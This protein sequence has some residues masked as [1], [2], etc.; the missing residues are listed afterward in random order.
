MSSYFVGNKFIYYV[1][2]YNRIN[3]TD[4]NF[5][6]KFENLNSEQF[7]R[8]VVLSASIPKSF[9][10]IQSGSNTFVLKENATQ[11]TI[12]VPQGNYNRNSLM[13]VVKTLLNEFSP[14]NWIYTISYSNI[15]LVGDDGKY[16]FTVTGNSSQ[17]PS[18]IFGNYLYEQLGFNSN[19]TYQFSSNSLVSINVCNL[20]VETTLFIHSDISQDF[21]SDNTLQEIYSNGEPSYSYINFINVCPHEYSKPLNNNKSNVFNFTLTDEYANIVETNGINVN[22]SVMVYKTN[23]FD[24][25]VKQYIQMKS[26]LL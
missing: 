5:S 25:M 6:Y 1:N 21:N 19:S 12:T 9:Y 8:V 22:F 15:S 17:Q 13:N 16:Y 10:L 14:N 26:M 18:F 3:G 2:S 11:V 7:D 24:E 4:S 23:P 20:S